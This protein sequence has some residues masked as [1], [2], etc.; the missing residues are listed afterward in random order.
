MQKLPC[1][2]LQK[3]MHYSYALLISVTI[4]TLVT[5]WEH[6]VNGRYKHNAVQTCSCINEN[7]PRILHQAETIFI[8]KVWGAILFVLIFQMNRNVQFIQSVIRAYCYK[9]YSLTAVPLQAWGGPVGSRKL[10]FPDFLTTAQDGGKI[11]SLMH[12]LHLSPGNTPGT[13]FC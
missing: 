10:R 3:I 13:H 7:T 5:E 12:W 8:S 11:V 1:Y 9:E 6:K 4:Q 2:Q